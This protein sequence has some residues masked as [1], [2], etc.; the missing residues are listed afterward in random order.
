VKKDDDQGLIRQLALLGAIPGLLAIGPL[1]GL[2]IGKFLD[3]QLHTEPY[4][5]FLF[6]IL[7]FI[8]AGRE[9]YNLVKK[10]SD[11]V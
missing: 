1:V 9:V 10:V 5:M 4:L 11:K 6:I 8:A 3:K 2:F 7:G